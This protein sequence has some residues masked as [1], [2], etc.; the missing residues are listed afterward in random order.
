[1]KEFI[2]SRII[3][4]VR[5]L[6]TGRVNELLQNLQYAIPV[7]EFGGY[8][9][10]SS[11]VPQIVLSSCERT[12]KER[13]VRQDAYSLIITISFPETS[14]SEMYCFAY[15]GAISRAF[16]DDPTLGG[17]ADRAVITGKK[18]L[19]PKKLLCGEDWEL[20]VSMKITV[21][22]MGDEG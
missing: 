7:I 19:A 1:M 3:G 16:Y 4:E 5:K 2:E 17:V 18:Y 6:L 10:A 11:V 8:E 21:E 9:G 22:G 15:S 20:Q 14:D 13:I 12:E